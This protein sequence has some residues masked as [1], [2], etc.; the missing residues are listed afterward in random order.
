[1]QLSEP[2]FEVKLPTLQ[3]E[4]LPVPVSFANLPAGQNSCSNFK[5]HDIV[6]TDAIFSVVV[7]PPMRSIVREIS[8][9]RTF[10]ACLN[11]LM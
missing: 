8:S 1:M 11:S 10:E 9:D 4:H 5:A 6:K 7:E 2:G 3:F